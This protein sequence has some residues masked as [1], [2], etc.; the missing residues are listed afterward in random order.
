MSGA[1][2]SV[3][4]EA[5]EDMGYYCIDNLPPIL[6]PKV[7]ELM[8]TADSH[9][10][11]VALG[12]ELRGK[13]VYE[14]LISESGELRDD[15]EIALEISFIDGS[16]GTLGNRYKETRRAHPID[17]TL[18]VLD[19]IHVERRILSELKGRANKIIDTSETSEKEL[20]N[21]I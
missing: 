1:G 12:I 6:L 5:V 17:N 15:N 18:N 14:S 11:Q 4:I 10:S 3:G 13:Q 9:E 16:D 20:R 8:E 7:V 19:A 2:K 21:K